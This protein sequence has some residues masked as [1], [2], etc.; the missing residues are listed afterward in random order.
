MSGSKKKLFSMDIEGMTC[1][2]C[3]HHVQD[4]LQSVGATDVHA[5]YKK[6]L[7]TFIA[8]LDFPVDKA[9]EAVAQAGYQP[10]DVKI[11]DPNDSS[12]MV[13]YHMDI[14]GMTCTDCEV[15]ITKALTKAG[16]SDVSA[17]FRRGEATFWA[18]ETLSLD[19][20]RQAVSEAGYKPKEVR[21]LSRTV[22]AEVTDI[23]HKT[24]GDQDYDLIVI[25][26]GSAAFGAAIEA[27]G[28]GFSVAMIERGTLGGT[29]VNI[30]CV[31]SK[32]L[33]RAS[34]LHHWAQQNPFQGLHTTANPADLKTLV[35]QKDELVQ[36]LR[37]KK[38]ADLLP[39]YE[40]D[41]IEG[42]ATFLDEHRLAVGDRVLTAGRY[43]IATGARPRI[44]DIAGLDSVPYLTSTSA[45]NLTT[46][47]KH[48][49]VIGSGYIALELGELFRH[50]GSEVTL[51]QRSPALMP[52]YDAEVRDIIQ[53]VMVSEGI[54]V[55]TGVQYDHVE[56]QGESIAVHLHV[57]GKAHTVIG[58]AL[59]V[60]AGRVPNTEAL[61]LPAAGVEQGAHGEPKTDETLRTTNPAIFAA[62]DVT[63]G[64]QFVYVAAYEGKIAAQNA[65]GLKPAV[66]TLKLDA[67]PAVTF[68]QPSIASVGMT[69]DQAKKKG[70]AV[71]SAVLPL[72][73]VTRA[74]ANRDTRGVFKLVA[75]EASGRIVGAQVVS[76]NAGDV[77]YAATLAVKFGLTIDDLTDSLAPYLTMAE[78][79]K[80][81]A[82]TF[83][84]DVSKLSCCAG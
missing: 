13:P 71:K 57:N 55:L 16:A 84:K 35:E 51:M 7:A 52:A 82:L 19:T 37:Q 26:S 48:L 33:L 44:P 12:E 39:E 49:L 45:L 6:G 34:D 72:E 74:L 41:L 53:D 66:Q 78:G 8:P 27:R 17:N 1:T 81:T 75:E 25:G 83:D 58:D 42:E 59:L 65:L 77:I 43:I 29:C 67:V 15:H 80:L 47:P 38:Y 61:N 70:I 22:N 31:P 63:M 62:G 56:K 36:E 24:R 46:R 9:Q 20:L 40:I 18:P 4:A 54:T 21:P 69:E 60:A 79:L 64:P 14:Q 2:S 32:T 28:A 23:K 68:T 30:G 11:Q 76:E 10:K 3:E 5:D 73:A 50:F